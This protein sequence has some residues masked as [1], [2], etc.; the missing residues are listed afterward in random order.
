MLALLLSISGKRKRK[1]KNVLD[2]LIRDQHPVIA[3]KIVRMIEESE[4]LK[5]ETESK[6][7]SFLMVDYSCA[8]KL[9]MPLSVFLLLRKQENMAYPLRAASLWNWFQ[10]QIQLF[11]I[12]RELSPICDG[13]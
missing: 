5:S 1:A 10:R 7:L 12:K 3:N 9:S 4:K 2:V 13:R 6:A 11:L 8:M